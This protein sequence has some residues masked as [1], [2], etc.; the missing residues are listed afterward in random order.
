MWLPL[1]HCCVC[2]LRW[3]QLFDIIQFEYFHVYA[4]PKCFRYSH[5]IYCV[6]SK[7]RNCNTV[8][9]KGGAVLWAFISA[10]AEE[11]HHLLWLSTEYQLSTTHYRYSAEQLRGRQTS[12]NKWVIHVSKNIFKTLP[13]SLFVNYNSFLSLDWL[14]QYVFLI[15]VLVSL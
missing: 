2:P 15:R 11:V 4:T 12:T 7:L 8:D 10:L 14:R 3:S 9:V 5:R 1:S 6:K 13:T